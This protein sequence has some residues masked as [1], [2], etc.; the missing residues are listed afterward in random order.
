MKI[1]SLI[2]VVVLC[3]QLGFASSTYELPTKIETLIERYEQYSDVD[4]L[5]KAFFMNYDGKDLSDRVSF[6]NHIAILR[7]VSCHYDDRY[8]T[9]RVLISSHATPPDGY[10]SGISPDVVEDPVERRKYVQRIE[11]NKRKARWYRVQDAI[12]REMRY[13]ADKMAYYALRGSISA[14]HTEEMVQSWGLPKAMSE[15]L[16]RM[17]AEISKRLNNKK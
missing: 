4:S 16:Y 11:E 5:E 7:R 14:E 15:E 6:T 12:R 13:V 3:S 10:D 8:G 17:I 9:V 2:T 1:V